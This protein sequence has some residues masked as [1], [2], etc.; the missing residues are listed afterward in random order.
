MEMRIEHDK[1]KMEAK[2]AQ[3]KSDRFMKDLEYQVFL[4]HIFVLSSFSFLLYLI[5]ALMA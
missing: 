5:N 2:F 1:I 4:L 3:E